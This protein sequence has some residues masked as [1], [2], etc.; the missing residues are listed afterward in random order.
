MLKKV[1][2]GISG[3]A[4]VI[5]LLA[6]AVGIMISVSLAPVSGTPQPSTTF[7]IPKGQ[8]VSVIANR[9]AEAGLIRHPLVFRVY[10]RFTQLE[11][12][13]QAGSFKLSATMTVSEIAQTLITGTDDLWITIPEGWRR[14]EIADALE[15]QSLSAF[16]KA[17]FLELTAGQEGKLFP[18][19]YLVSRDATTESLVRLLLNTFDQKITTGLATEIENSKYDLDEALVMASLLE[20]EAVGY[21]EM[22][23][24]AGILYNRI[25]LGMSLDVDASLQ[26]AKGYDK[27]TQKW[28]P[29]V[30]SADKEIVS[31]FNTYRNP[32]LPPRPIANPGL[33]AI[34]AALN[35]ANVDDLFYIHDP[36]GQIH[37]AKTLDQHNANVQKYLR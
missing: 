29:D 1:V 34:K 5:A 27:N 31:P 35:P 25:E 14:E 4:L 6:V 30:Y 23:R 9:L 3:L 7:V 16:D 22:R 11:P 33:E 26:Y 10:V 24:V 15:R 28:W 19:T 18:D 20:R 37:Y 17:T 8:A 36:S 32:G 13:L 2:I 21:D 12:K